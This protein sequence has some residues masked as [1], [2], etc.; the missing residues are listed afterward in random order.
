MSIATAPD[1][2]D[3]RL[4]PPRPTRVALARFDDLRRAQE[5]AER[6]GDAGVPETAIDVVAGRLRWVEAPTSR[7]DYWA[8][9]VDGL[10]A[11][12]VFGALFGAIWSAASMGGDNGTMVLAV[13]FG[14]LLGAAVGVIL[15]IVLHW[16]END[17]ERQGAIE[18][19]EFDLLVDE[20]YEDDARTAVSQARSGRTGRFRR[21]G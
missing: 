10:R 15:G 17:P 5:A 19:E 14:A 6:V 21:T 9:A 11:G 16:G 7:S 4:A 2:L 1:R 3:E 13:L 12:G 18:A 8:A 20:R